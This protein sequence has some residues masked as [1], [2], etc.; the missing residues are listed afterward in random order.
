M[1]MERLGRTT[2]RWVARSAEQLNGF[3]TVEGGSEGT[4]YHIRFRSR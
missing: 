4:A 1:S 2:T 3:M